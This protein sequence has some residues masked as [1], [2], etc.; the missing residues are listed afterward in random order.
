MAWPLVRS[1]KKSSKKKEEEKHW[2]PPPPTREERIM[3]IGR[4]LNMW[5]EFKESCVPGRK[6]YEDYNYYFLRD[7]PYDARIDCQ[8]TDETAPLWRDFAQRQLEICERRL[9]EEIGR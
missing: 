6:V 1:N 5:R 4:E 7:H 9:R 8:M 2:T 3:N